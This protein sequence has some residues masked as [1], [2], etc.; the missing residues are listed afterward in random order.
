[1]PVRPRI[2]VITRNL[3]PLR[4]GMERLNFHLLRELSAAFELRVC[5][6]QECIPELP[7]GVDAAGVP[8]RPLSRFVLASTVAA[9]SS[10]R[11]FRPHLVLAG[12]GL[13]APMARIA[14]AVAGARSA[15]Y[16]HGLD[17]LADH[18]AYR[19]LWVPW[20]AGL[21]AVFVNSRHT[22]ELAARAR[23]PAHRINIVHP[24]VEL[25]PW[26]PGR[27][28]EFRQ[29]FGLGDRPMLLS[30][31]RLTARKGLAEFIERALPAL[32]SAQPRIV[33]VVIGAEAVNSIKVD[34]QSQLARIQAAVQRLGLEDNVRLLGT[35]DDA[36]VRGAFF[37]A[38]ALVFPLID[39]PGDTEG[40]G[41]VAVEAAA[42]GTPTVAF[43]VGGAS[44]SV[45][46]PVSGS[47]IPA[48][49]Y[50]A[51]IRTLN[52]LLGA[53]EEATQAKLARREFAAGFEWSR[54]GERIR[55]VCHSRLS[56][57]VRE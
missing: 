53:P 8:L 55:S 44:D 48:G 12:S 37:A 45:S 17:I 49:D 11:R 39:L 57:G 22:A 31:G 29:G 5:C 41:M 24:G 23:V 36:I 25:P 32:V 18:W 33:L 28:E 14:A 43:A 50:L 2:L 30:V 38:R 56:S 3:P 20:F 16:L 1:M 47:L 34:T 19:N 13:T 42:H 7:D 10:A 26:E 52:G 51:M 9:V 6:P 4:G 21:D 15:A 54:F 46:D 27:G 35:Q 40:F